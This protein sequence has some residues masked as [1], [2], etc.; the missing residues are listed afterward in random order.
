MVHQVRMRGVSFFG[1]A[2]AGILF[3]IALSVVLA[4]LSMFVPITDPETGEV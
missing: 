2:G 1:F 4:V 3:V